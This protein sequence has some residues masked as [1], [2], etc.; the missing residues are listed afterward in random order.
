[1]REGMRNVGSA[2]Y[3]SISPRTVESH[4]ARIMSK[5]G[6]TSRTE[7]IKTATDMGFLT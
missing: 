1:M 7:A 5:L 4:V 3:L 6:A 2:E